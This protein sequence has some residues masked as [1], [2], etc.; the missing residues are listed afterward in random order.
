LKHNSFTLGNKLLFDNG[1]HNPSGSG[2]LIT[3]SRIMSFLM[4]SQFGGGWKDSHASSLQSHLPLAAFASYH[5]SGSHCY[6]CGSVA[7]VTAQMRQYC[8][9]NKP[10]KVVKEGQNGFKQGYKGFNQGHMTKYLQT[11]Q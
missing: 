11:L 6:D 3:A 9:T 8:E 10:E 2:G 1:V 4:A 5:S 7:T